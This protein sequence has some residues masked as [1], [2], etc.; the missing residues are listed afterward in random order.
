MSEHD[1]RIGRLSP[2]QRALLDRWVT[3]DLA[4]AEADPDADT[5]AGDDAYPAAARP[6]HRPPGTGAERVLAA[7]W[8][9]VLEADRVGLDDDYFALGGDSIHAIVIVAKARQAGLGVE[10]QDLFEARTLAEVAARATEVSGPT[11]ADPAPAGPRTEHRLTPMQQGMLYHSAGGST[12]GA[13]VVQVCC[14]LTGELDENAFHDAWQ[15]VVSA[16][17]ALCAAFR[18]ADRPLPVQVVDPAARIPLESADWRQRT[19]AERAG[20]FDRFLDADRERGFDLTHAPL[21]RLALFREDEHAYRC[22]W[23]HHHLVLDGWSQQL[24]LRDVLECYARLRAG[25]AAAPPRRPPFS[26]YLDRLAGREGADEA[27]W[28]RA[29]AGVPGPSRV[30]GPGC[31]DGQVVAVRRAEREHRLT[32]ATGEALTAFC[33]RHGLTP[34]AVLHG[35]WATLLAAHCGQ[36]D[37]VFGTTLAGRP[38]DL[39]GVTEC[40]GLFINTLPLRVRCGATTSTLQWL[41]GLQRDLTELR[42]HEHVPLSRVERGLGLGWGDGLFDSI[43][44]V[45]NFPAW[46]ADGHLA[47]GLRV[48]RPTALVDEGYPLV[49]EATV[50]GS[51]ALRARY[52]PHRVD[53]HRLQAR[54]A[55]FDDYLQLVTGDPGRPLPALR[56]ELA[57]GHARRDDTARGRRREEDR[58]R[59]ALARRQTTEGETP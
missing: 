5:Y 15:A 50:G 51:P 11:A 34:A 23:T 42:A 14:R 59:L 24:V 43:L 7:V 37:V 53:G 26:D 10:A 54:L 8:Q 2:A 16:N 28:R 30:A 32:V 1:E 57:R 39:P 3:E 35:G 29:L 52:D 33:R 56:A 46:V 40:V 12:P 44:V 41:H 9:E 6:A 17:P 22:V 45:E 4:E 55:A 38:A 36:D 49:L 20:D 18:W 58:T 13:Y 27:Y 25:R 48:E 21:A 19:P 31:R 47:G